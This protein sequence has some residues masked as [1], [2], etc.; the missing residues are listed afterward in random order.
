MIKH[1]KKFINNINKKKFKRTFF[2]SL[3]IFLLIIII[4]SIGFTYA[5]YESDT[6]LKLNPNIAFFIVD[7]TNTTKSLELTKM[8]PSNDYYDYYFEV[9][10]FNDTGK[11]NVDLN[12][13]IKLKMTTNLP[14]TYEIYKVEDNT[15]AN[16]NT[17]NIS[18]NQDGMYFKEYV[19]TN[20]YFMACKTKKT[21]RFLLRVY[22]PLEYKNNPDYYESVIDLVEININATQV[23]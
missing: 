6:T 7:A 2:S 17:V 19:D 22:F 4:S 1:L 3:V 20:D 11:A 10:N 23:V 15:M 9:S 8:V 16:I 21:D 12:Y 13:N 18:T 5:R 14:L